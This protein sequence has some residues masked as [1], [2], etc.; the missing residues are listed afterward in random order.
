MRWNNIA[1]KP[2]ICRTGQLAIVEVAMVIIICI[3]EASVAPSG[4][5]P[6]PES[7]I[8]EALRRLARVCKVVS[9]PASTSCGLFVDA[10]ESL[11]TLESHITTEG[12]L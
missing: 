7:A 6:N 1:I 11:D 8:S 2:V 10:E 9:G 3:C 5:H 12:V 4:R